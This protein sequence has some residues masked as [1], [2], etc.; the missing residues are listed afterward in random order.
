MKK[1]INFRI[2]QLLTGICLLIISILIKAENTMPISAVFLG[3]GGGMFVLGIMGLVTNHIERSN[4]VMKKKKEI[5]DKDERNTMIRHCAKARAGDI[6][7][8]LI[9]A[10]AYVTILISAPMWVTL[11]VVCVFVFYNV[12]GILLINKYQNEM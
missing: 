7:Q 5:E 12:A 11:F 4:P 10:I 9:M 8:W 2:L 1:K 6:T 3:V